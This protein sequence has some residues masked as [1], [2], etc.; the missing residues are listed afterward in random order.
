MRKKLSIIIPFLGLILACE[1][2]VDLN[3]DFEET[4]VVFGLLDHNA[5][6]QFIKINKTFLDDKESAID[7]AQQGDR[8][9]YDS[10]K[11][12][13]IE[14]EGTDT[15]RLE[16]INRPKEDGIFTTD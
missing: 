8:I 4:A 6:T 3:T 1:N 13:L 15:F 9:F 14:K 5:D 16:K 10:L 12:S 7:L 11:V 2:E